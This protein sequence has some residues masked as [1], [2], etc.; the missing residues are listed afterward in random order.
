MDDNDFDFT[1]VT[2]TSVPTRAPAPAAEPE[3]TP[4]QAATSAQHPDRQ[5]APAQPSQ[6]IA[7]VEELLEAEPT[8]S[9]PRRGDRGVP[10]S[11]PLLDVAPPRGGAAGLDE[12][13][14][15]ADAASHRGPWWERL[16][17]GGKARRR[18]DAERRLLRQLTQPLAR[19]VVIAVANTKGGAGKTPSVAGLASALGVERGGVVA[20]DLWLRGNLGERTVSH[21]ST[22]STQD[23]RDALNVLSAPDARGGDVSRLIELDRAPR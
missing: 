1:H 15:G 5:P 17:I 23:F 21:G 22:L 19:P 11:G 9:G 7:R 14:G 4:E 3:T 16:G 18:R 10:Y 13:F 2:T 12:M 20:L 6:G 8:P